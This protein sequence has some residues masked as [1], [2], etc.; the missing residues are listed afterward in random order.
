MPRRACR[1]LMPSS[2]RPELKAPV[3]GPCKMH[4]TWVCPYPASRRPSSPAASPLAPISAL[5][6]RAC[7]ARERPS[8]LMTPMPSLRTSDA[9]STRP[10][11]SPTR[12]GSTR[13]LRVPPSTSGT[14]RKVTSRKSGGVDASSARS[15]STALPRPTLPTPTWSRSLSPRISARQSLEP[16]R[17]GAESLRPPQPPE[18]PP[19]RSPR[20]WPTTT[21]FVPP[22][23]PPPSCRGSENFSVLTP[24][25]GLHSPALSPPPRSPRRWPTTTAFVPPVYPPPS[26]RGSETF[27]VL[28]PTGG[29]TSRARSTPSGRVIA[30][31]S[32][33]HR[34]RTNTRRGTQYLLQGTGVPTPKTRRHNGQTRC[35]TPGVR[36]RLCGPV[37]HARDRAILKHLVDG[38]CQQRRNRQN[39]QWLPPFLLRHRKRVGHANLVNKLGLQDLNCRVGEDRVGGRDNN[40]HRTLLLQRLGRLHNRAPSVNEIVH[41]QAHSA[42]D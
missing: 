17:A 34:P 9:R 3:H 41:E 19:P 33:Q 15:F 25:G 14:L 24:T 16:K 39:R 20:R 4:S 13:S 28:T 2:T 21:A 36:L 11:S 8:A 30:Q 37:E 10:R 35:R 42:L 6:P 18:S 1:W 27:S 40:T 26:C 23:Y 7:P 5:R 38:S 32:Q 29:L 22:V 12:K 31:R